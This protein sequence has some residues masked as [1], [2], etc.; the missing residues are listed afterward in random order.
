[1]FTGNVVWSE[2]INDEETLAG[3]RQWTRL[4]GLADGVRAE[5][6][7]LHRFLTEEKGFHLLAQHLPR[8][9]VGRIEPVVVDDIGQLRFPLI[10]GLGR[11]VLVDALAEWTGKGGLFETGQLLPELGAH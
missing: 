2:M 10:I 5:V 4:L 6:F 7:R 9:G 3:A 8:F 11:N 1:R